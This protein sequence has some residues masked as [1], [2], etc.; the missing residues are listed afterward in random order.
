MADLTD[1]LMRDNRAAGTSESIFIQGGILTYQLPA[2]LGRWIAA[3]RQV[4]NSGSSVPD[5]PY[6]CPAG[7]FGNSTEVSVQ[8]S[9]ACT[10]R[11]P[12][13]R[14]CLGATVVP[15]ACSAGGYCP[16][17]SVVALRKWQ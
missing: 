11:C 15:Y 16:I 7:L 10:G 3:S 2:P 9:P 14:V 1:T 5:Y 4:I 17:G 8:T 12:A 13:G 6:A